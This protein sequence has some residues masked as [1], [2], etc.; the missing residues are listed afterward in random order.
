LNSFFKVVSVR[1]YK[2]GNWGS[3]SSL[4]KEAEYKFRVITDGSVAAIG[5]TDR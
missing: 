2:S 5:E 4:V 3:E 1:G